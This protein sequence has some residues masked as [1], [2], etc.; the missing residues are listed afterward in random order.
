MVGS[1][2]SQMNV[3]EVKTEAGQ[4]E[5][6]AKMKTQQEEMKTK[7]HL[8]RGGKGMPKSNE[9]LSRGYGG[10]SG[11]VRNHDRGHNGTL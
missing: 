1:L 10:Q 8:D 5:M 7:T 2:A 4:E 9:G 3:N 11:K 6:I